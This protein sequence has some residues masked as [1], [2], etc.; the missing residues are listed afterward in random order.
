M[1][2][3]YYLFFKMRV[4]PSALRY[5]MICAGYLFASAIWS[6]A[7]SIIVPK[8][9]SL[10]GADEVVAF[11]NWTYRGPTYLPDPIDLSGNTPPTPPVESYHLEE[12]CLKRFL[13]FGRMEKSSTDESKYGCTQLKDLG[14][15]KGIF[16]T[17]KHEVFYWKM[18]NEHF[19]MYGTGMVGGRLSAWPTAVC[20]SQDIRRTNF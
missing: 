10:P 16:F 3:L 18:G 4:T 11:A 20:L 2:D 7:D 6:S 9:E 1:T 12:S 15:P 8:L 19:S 13:Q 14:L 5:G 17:S